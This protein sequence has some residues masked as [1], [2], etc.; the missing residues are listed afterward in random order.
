MCLQKLLQSKPNFTTIPVILSKEMEV[1][2]H[3]K[4]AAFTV[5]RE[6][7]RRSCPTSTQ[8]YEKINS[9]N[10][11]AYIIRKDLNHA[12]HHP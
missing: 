5:S 7:K 2:L 9:G 11:D 3:F 8:K 10:I 4:Q 1:N 6:H 12:G